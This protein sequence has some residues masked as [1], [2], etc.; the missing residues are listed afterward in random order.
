M[1]APP[2][3]SA[4]TTHFQLPLLYPGQAQKEFF[5]NEAF[6]L[7]DAVLNRSV[8]GIAV[9]PPASPPAGEAWLAGAGAQG[10]WA[11]FDDHICIFFGEAWHFVAPRPG[12]SAFNE[13]TG[14]RIF[15]SDAWLEASEPSAPTGGATVDTEARAAIA[16]LVEALQKA[17]IFVGN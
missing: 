2:E 11:G 13:S 5:V 8:K 1:I 12:L 7:I 17:Q 3:Y 9:A 14:A 10:E 15:F 6:A 4:K 16:A